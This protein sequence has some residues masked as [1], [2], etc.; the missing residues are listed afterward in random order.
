MHTD[1]SDLPQYG[2]VVNNA[3]TSQFE[4]PDE[5]DLIDLQFS[6]NLASQPYLSLGLTPPSQLSPDN[7]DMDFFPSMPP[8]VS[9]SVSSLNTSM[10]M[11]VDGPFDD[12]TAESSFMPEAVPIEQHR[13]QRASRKSRIDTRLPTVLETETP[14]DSFHYRAPQDFSGSGHS[15]DIEEPISLMFP[16]AYSST[17]AYQGSKRR[18]SSTTSK[19]VGLTVMRND[20]ADHSQHIDS[21]LPPQNKSQTE[22]AYQK[23]ASTEKEMRE[24][25][26]KEELARQKELLRLKKEE[27]EK[28]KREST[29]AK[30]LREYNG[31]RYD[32]DTEQNDQQNK[33]DN[34]VLKQAAMFEAQAELAAEGSQSP[35]AVRQSM[36]RS[37][38]SGGVQRRDSSIKALSDAEKNIGDPVK[39][40]HVQVTRL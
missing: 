18:L 26:R 32:Y 16:S 21:H 17:A 25:A 5:D 9:A 7:A 38:T 20:F 31:W 33:A 23:A 11:S 24:A 22:D 40:S 6:E 39:H 37:N 34:I 30:I 27:E 19:D 1:S 4:S 29:K 2:S 28:Q 35:T 14:P 12:H 36:R 8:P 10:G 3:R 13:N 15:G